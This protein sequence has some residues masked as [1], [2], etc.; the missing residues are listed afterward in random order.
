[1][2][3][4]DLNTGLNLR[5]ANSADYEEWLQSLIAQG[6]IK[7]DEE[8]LKL[9]AEFRLGSVD[10]FIPPKVVV[11]WGHSFKGL[12][13]EMWNL[14][15]SDLRVSDVYLKSENGVGCG[16]LVDVENEG[17]RLATIENLKLN[18]EYWPLH[19]LNT[20][21]PSGIYINKGRLKLEIP[22][23]PD[24]D[25]TPR[26]LPQ[27][28]L[29]KDINGKALCHLD[30][31]LQNAEEVFDLSRELRQ[32]NQ[33]PTSLG[34]SSALFTLGQIAEVLPGC[35]DPKMKFYPA[36]GNPI[37]APLR[38]VKSVKGLELSLSPPDEGVHFPPMGPITKGISLWRNSDLKNP[39]SLK[40]KV[41]IDNQYGASYVK[42]AE[43][44]D[45]FESEADLL[46]QIPKRYQTLVVRHADGKEESYSL[47]GAEQKETLKRLKYFIPILYKYGVKAAND[48][49]FVYSHLKIPHGKPAE[50]RLISPQKKLS[51]YNIELESQGDIEA[52]EIHGV[53]KIQ[54][55]LKFLMDVKLAAKGSLNNLNLS[56]WIL[57]IQQNGS[58][59][60]TGNINVPSMEIKGIKT[61][62]VFFNLK[63]GRNYIHA[64]DFKLSLNKGEL[65]TKGLLDV[66]F[67][68]DALGFNLPNGDKVDLP[69]SAGFRMVA[70]ASGQEQKGLKA[71]ML[72]HHVI[73]EPINLSSGVLLKKSQFGFGGLIEVLPQKDLSQIE[74]KLSI[75]SDLSM[76]AQVKDLNIKLKKGKFKVFPSIL[77]VDTKTND[78]VAAARFEHD[79]K[80][81]VKG[82][83]FKASATAKGKGE[84]V[85]VNKAANL[86]YDGNVALEGRYKNNLKAKASGQL[87]GRLSLKADQTGIAYAGFNGMVDDTSGNAAHVDA[88]FRGDIT[89]DKNKNVVVDSLFRTILNGNISSVDGQGVLESHATLKT[90]KHLGKESFHFWADDFLLAGRLK[91]KQ[92]HVS[93]RI[94]AGKN[95]NNYKKQ[96][97]YAPGIE[98]LATKRGELIGPKA[99]ASVNLNLSEMAIDIPIPGLGDSKLY[100]SGQLVGN[101]DIVNLSKTAV[102]NFRPVAGSIGFEILNAKIKQLVDGKLVDV[103]EKTR[104]K[105]TDNGKGSINLDLRLKRFKLAGKSIDIDLSDI[106][107]STYMNFDAVKTAVVDGQKIKYYDI[108]EIDTVGFSTVFKAME[109]NMGALYSKASGTVTGLQSNVRKVKLKGRIAIN[110][111]EIRFGDKKQGGSIKYSKGNVFTSGEATIVG[112]IPKKA[113]IRTTVALPEKVDLNWQQQLPDGSR[114]AVVGALKVKA[115]TN[116]DIDFLRRKARFNS[117]KPIHISGPVTLKHISKDGTVQEF[118]LSVEH[119]ASFTSKAQFKDG[120]EVSLNIPKMDLKA[121]LLEGLDLSGIKV[122]K[123]SS[124]T[125]PFSGFN[126]LVKVGYKDNKIQMESEFE[127]FDLYDYDKKQGAIINVL[128]SPLKNFLAP[129]DGPINIEIKGFN[130][131]QKYQAEFDG[132]KLGVKS[133]GKVVA[134]DLKVGA[135]IGEK[136]K[137]KDLD[138]SVK[139]DT[140]GKITG[141]FDLASQRLKLDIDNVKVNSEVD[142]VAKLIGKMI[143]LDNVDSN[144]LIKG[145]HVDLD[146]KSKKAKVI[147]K[148]EQGLIRHDLPKSIDEFMSWDSKKWADWRQALNKHKHLAKL[149]EETANLPASKLPRGKGRVY[150]NIKKIDLDIDLNKLQENSLK[151]LEGLQPELK[152]KYQIH[153]EWP[154]PTIPDGYKSKASIM[155]SRGQDALFFMDKTDI[156]MI[157]RIQNVF[158]FESNDKAVEMFNNGRVDIEDILDIKFYKDNFGHEVMRGFV[159]AML[160]Q[161]ESSHYFSEAGDRLLLILADLRDGLSGGYDLVNRKN[162]F[163]GGKARLTGSRSYPEPIHQGM[164]PKETDGIN[165]TGIA[166]FTK[167]ADKV[168]H[169]IRNTSSHKK[170]IPGIKA[171]QNVAT[172]LMNLTFDND[173]RANVYYHQENHNGV[174]VLDLVH[175][176][177]KN[178]SELNL[179]ADRYMVLPHKKGGSLLVL[180]Q[181]RDFNGDD[182]EFYKGKDE[183]LNESVYKAKSLFNPNY[184]KDGFEWSKPSTYIKGVNIG[185]LN[186]SNER[187][188]FPNKNI[189][190]VNRFLFNRLA[191][192]LEFL[193]ENERTPIDL[194]RGVKKSVDTLTYLPGTTK[195]TAPPKEFLFVE[196]D[197]QT[198]KILYLK[199]KIEDDEVE[200]VIDLVREGLGVDALAAKKI[201][202]S[203]KIEIETLLNLPFLKERYEEEVIYS[204]IQTF[205]KAIPD[206]F[207]GV[208]S[209]GERFLTYLHDVRLR[210]SG[211]LGNSNVALDGRAYISS[212]YHQ[213]STH[214]NEDPSDGTDSMVMTGIPKGVDRLALLK[215]T[216]EPENFVDVDKTEEGHIRDFKSTENT[217]CPNANE[218]ERCVKTKLDIKIA[219]VDYIL[220]VKKKLSAVG[221]QGLVYL[222]KETK[223]IPKNH[224][225]VAPWWWQQSTGFDENQ[226]MWIMIPRKDGGTDFSRMGFLNTL[227]KGDFKASKAAFGPLSLFIRG[228]HRQALKATRSNQTPININYSGLLFNYNSDRGKLDKDKG[229]QKLE[230]KQEGPK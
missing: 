86:N 127:P 51:A 62:G 3:A 58:V 202:K 154:N 229:K 110:P 47:N 176:K 105:L 174:K 34:L 207:P 121:T 147:I 42:Q 221:P 130:N 141:T 161:T 194:N 9:N 80:L 169:H 55:P 177:A 66:S 158:K 184:K 26:I 115:R 120:A 114:I 125:L 103:I 225:G 117:K 167:P 151:Y 212:R 172:G 56:D 162:T 215:V 69:G 185:A 152:N 142:G 82:S 18:P 170:F 157:D 196:S 12:F 59:T 217:S 223:V 104:V 230:N 155:Y 11:D 204:L 108:P 60:S 40:A 46:K 77:K 191:S 209:N 22:Y 52:L 45:S 128:G 166:Y 68:S 74:A 31:Y 181:A 73:N 149:S 205:L 208:L 119:K 32:S 148:P 57:S 48:D 188:A 192:N 140:Q 228:F 224:I 39:L 70:G 76:E 126:A 116:G 216:S 165:M 153:R 200:R 214:N 131:G 8:P 93:T 50:V 168:F 79:H 71:S 25:L 118:K 17:I 75:E 54:A 219:K 72:G 101:M 99:H 21:D 37:L 5:F 150:I 78:I 91:A 19:Y 132:E 7:P 164:M 156:K 49:L 97:V 83:T 111:N 199:F 159:D 20:I 179:L 15:G 2:S 61:P 173:Q 175:D 44:N 35:P 226:G 190:D 227:E 30:S 138:L 41:N 43:V 85:V 197:P 160:H 187:A 195:V 222:D 129:M 106:V 178:S 109:K 182:V 183:D 203:G 201:I 220:K 28:P 102:P 123:G 94:T 113:K 98:V 67:A 112:T 87:V 135:K 16:D 96:K 145:V 95:L 136:D 92:G 36:P 1:M 134:Y 53:G 84:I 88:Q 189:Y 23:A 24:E 100:I 14:E 6:I 89:K 10:V 163:W 64:N 90:V 210:G 171:S 144:V 13:S 133:K 27:L 81:E 206:F 218:D 213:W 143:P 139:T 211:W 137:K 180:Q 63:T 107:N 193:L 124:V 29:G 65:Q 38:M 122:A 33:V 186:A 146:V 198:K 4:F